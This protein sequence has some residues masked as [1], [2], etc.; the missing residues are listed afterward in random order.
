MTLRQCA[1]FMDLNIPVSIRQFAKMVGQAE[2]AVR[3]AR[4]RESILKGVT[5][6]GKIIPSVASAEWGKEILPEF[7]GVKKS[8][9]KK[10]PV[11]KTPVVKKTPT[12]KKTKKEPETI[13]EYVA[14]IMG[15]KLPTAGADDLDDDT[16]SGD[17]EESI[18]KTEAERITSVLKAKILQITYAEKKGQ[19]VPIDKVNSVLFGYGQEIRNAFE[20]IPDRIIDRI[21]ALADKRHEAK[22]VLVDEIHDTLK[23]LSDIETR[24]SL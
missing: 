24:D 2:S 18:P 3:K 10:S 8:V 22:R 1:Q 12:V 19:L 21:L 16:V 14:E 13:D 4:N 23:L 20:S 5:A 11:A 15:E 7:S 17:L 9:P 6:D